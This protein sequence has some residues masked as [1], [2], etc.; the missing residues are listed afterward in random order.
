MIDRPNAGVTNL[1]LCMLS[2]FVFMPVHN[3]L[4]G[5][6]IG[7]LMLRHYYTEHK[8]QCVISAGIISLGHR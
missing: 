3:N 7:I 1:A 5:H 2:A 4:S 8:S 6:T